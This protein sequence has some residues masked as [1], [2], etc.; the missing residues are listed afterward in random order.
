MRR[1][2]GTVG[3]TIALPKKFSNC[4]FNGVVAYNTNP[5]TP[6]QVRTGTANS[7]GY[8]M[9]IKN[10]ISKSSQLDSCWDIPNP[11]RWFQRVG[12]VCEMKHT[13]LLALICS[14]ALVEWLLVLSKQVSM[15]LPRLKSIHSLQL[16]NL[17]FPFGLYYAKMLLTLQERRKHS[18]ISGKRYW[19]SIWSPPCQGFSLIGKRLIDD[20]RNSLVLHFVRLVL[21]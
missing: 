21:G 10:I 5:T 12:M 11:N 7:P 1:S 15:C 14:L 8:R 20:P 4:Y 19:C 16:T 18:S 9:Q 3:V 2:L 17:I 13:D 6:K